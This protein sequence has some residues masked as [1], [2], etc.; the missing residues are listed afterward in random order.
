MEV[1]RL[2]APFKVISYYTISHYIT[3]LET[4]NFSINL[5]YY[6]N[7][8]EIFLLWITILSFGFHV[9]TVRSVY[10]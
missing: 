1:Q 3:R 8:K 6:I 10:Y 9:I 4:N 2:N 7:F 5:T